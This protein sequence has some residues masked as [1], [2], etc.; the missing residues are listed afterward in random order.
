M[1][2]AR[3][4]RLVLPD[5]QRDFVWKP[6]DVVKLLSSLLNGYPIGGLLVMEN[7]GVY[8]QRVLD[9]VSAGTEKTASGDKRLWM[10]SNV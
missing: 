4:G 2:Q 1:E 6:T 3:D 8:G 9:G 7:P 5:F 10:G